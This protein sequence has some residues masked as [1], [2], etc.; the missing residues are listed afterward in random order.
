VR[1]AEGRAVGEE[2][3]RLEFDEDDPY[4]A[5]DDLAAPGKDRAGSLSIVATCA[6]QKSAGLFLYDVTSSYLE[7]AQ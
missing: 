7:G 2:L 4:E 1:W 6:T 3:G 5:L